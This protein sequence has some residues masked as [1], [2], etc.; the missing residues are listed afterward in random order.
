MH[1]LRFFNPY[2][3]IR[4][5]GSRLPHWQQQG[6]VYFL[7]FRLADSIPLRLR[8]QWENEREAW[9]KVHPEPWTNETEREYH[10]RFS[11]AIERWL[12]AGHGACLLRR[13]DC[14]QI[15]A[16][17]LRHFE[18]ERVVMM[19]FV[20]M[21]N[22][23]HALFVQNPEWPL[24]KLIQSWK[25]FIARELNKLLSRSGNLWQRD[26]FDRLV[27]DENHCAN[28]VRYIRRNREKA[29]LRDGE[30]ILYE[31]DIARAIC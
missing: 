15:V 25:R 1:E 10:R 21:P 3:E 6:A 29:N 30:Y 24:E 9:L 4:H 17:T 31:S 27:R 18:G 28:C 8:D 12:D 11:G 23:V 22:H 2:A 7:T 20:V 19:S 26:Y 13:P 5:T 16:D 14:A